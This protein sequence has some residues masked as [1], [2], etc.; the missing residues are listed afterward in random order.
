MGVF[1]VF[2]YA[3]ISRNAS[4]IKEGLESEIKIH[5][6]DIKTS[7]IV[8]KPLSAIWM[9]KF[10]NVMISKKVKPMILNS[11]RVSH[12]LVALEMSAEKV[13]IL[14]LFEACS[15]FT[16]IPL[17]NQLTTTRRNNIQNIKSE[18]ECFVTNRADKNTFDFFLSLIYR[19]LQLIICFSSRE[20]LTF[21]VSHIVPK[22]TPLFPEDYV[23]IKN[24]RTYFAKLSQSPSSLAVLHH[25]Q[26]ILKGKIQN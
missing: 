9:I 7:L 20:S 5:D 19:C 21:E 16:S 18:L 1:H 24:T 22:F 13:P 26:A 11:W 3:T 2:T 17:K 12:I 25:I 6:I 10:Y 23:S 4:H 14:D 8:S 15:L